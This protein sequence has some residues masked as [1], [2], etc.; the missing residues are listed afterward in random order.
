RSVN[1]GPALALR[2]DG[3]LDSIVAVHVEG[4]RITGLYA[5]RNP[6]KLSRIESATPLTLR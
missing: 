6:G 1:G 4:V 5:V 2:L 3:E